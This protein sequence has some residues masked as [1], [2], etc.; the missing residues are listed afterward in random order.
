MSDAEIEAHL[1]HSLEEEA[2]NERKLVSR[3]TD[4]VSEEIIDAEVVEVEEDDANLSSGG[5]I[6]RAEEG[7]DASLPVR[8]VSTSESRSDVTHEVPKWSEPWWRSQSPE[9]Q[10]RRCRGHKKTGV[11]CGNFAIQGA[12]VCR[13]HGGAAPHVKAAARARLENAADRMARN[14]L[15]L[16]ETADSDAVRVKATD[17]ALDRSGLKAP[18]EVFLAPGAPKPYEEIF[19]D[20]GGGSR[21]ESRARRGYVDSDSGSANEPAGVSPSEYET[22]SDSVEYD[23]GYE[24]SNEGAFDA[25]NNPPTQGDC[26]Y[27][28]QPVPPTQ[29]NGGGEATPAGKTPEPNS[30]ARVYPPGDPRGGDRRQR[31]KGHADGPQ[32]GEP[33]AARPPHRGDR[34]DGSLNRSARAELDDDALYLARVANERSGALPAQRAI[35]SSHRRYRYHRR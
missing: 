12:T 29:R 10:A 31:A 27:P 23:A 20:I 7:R 4:T 25:S 1:G 13:F 11:R 17:S 19:E 28:T 6:D 30:D 14:L 34:G 22:H 32:A 9:I 33:N 26:S 2:T 21:E 8:V 24:S 35:E 16:A 3:R 5:P 15:E 18:T